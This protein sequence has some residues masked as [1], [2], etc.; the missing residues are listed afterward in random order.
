MKNVFFETYGCQMN[1]A[2]SDNLS[3][4]LTQKNNFKVV[5]SPNEADFVVINTCSVRKTAETRIWGRLGF[6][7]NLAQTHNFTLIVMGCMAERLKDDLINSK[8]PVDI[9]VGTNNKKKLAEIISNYKK[10]TKIVLTG[11]DEYG[12]FFKYSSPD[13]E[14]SLRAFV[15]ISHGCNN[16]CSYC[17]VPY[18]RGREKSRTTHEIIDDINKLT[19]QGVKEI[20]LLGQNVNSYGNDS[21]DIPF[22]LLLRKIIAETDVENIKFLSSHPKDFSDELIDEISSNRR[23]SR[24]VHLALQSGSNR[25]LELMNRK[26]TAELYLN[27]VKM[28]KQKVSGLFLTTD[29]ITGFSTETEDEFLYT[30]D[31]MKE[32]RFDDAYMYKYSVREGTDAHKR[33]VDDVPDEVKVERLKKIIDMQN[34]INIENKQGRIGSIFKTIPDKI[35]RRNSL[36]IHSTTFENI[37]IVFR[38]DT[39]HLSRVLS[40]RATGLKG[41]TMIGELV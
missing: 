21:G 40:V 12:D 36:Q 17:I 41:V 13:S 29:I 23:I 20:T 10:N 30:Y 15:N 7:K 37:P 28:L 38:G 31:L 24:W 8:F 6:Y 14:N 27:I 16:F 1:K 9:V 35:S 18:L 33:F 34:I 25:I 3:L 32:I 5:F 26:Y 19:L 11:F 39:S 2:D 22:Y 4:E